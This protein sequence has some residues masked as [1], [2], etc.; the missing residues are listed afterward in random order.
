MPKGVRIKQQGLSSLINWE[1]HTYEVTPDDRATMLAGLGFDASVWEIW[2]CLAIGAGLYQIDEEKRSNP[3][4]LYQWLADQKI[5]ISFLPTPLAEVVLDLPVPDDISLRYLFTGGDALHARQ[6]QELPFT[7]VNH[8]GPSENTVIATAGA[9]PQ[10]L[11]PTVVPHIGRP[12]DNTRCYILDMNLQAVPLGVI[13]E[14]CL[15]GPAVADGYQ[16]QE[17]L[18]TDRFVKNPYADGDWS[19]LYKTGDRAYFNTD[20]TIEFLGRLDD[21]VKIRGFR[22]ELG[23]IES[24]LTRH[25]SIA[26]AAA[27]VWTVNRDDKRVVAYVVP[28]DGNEELDLVSLRKYLRSSLPA[29]MIPTHFL[30]LEALPE[31]SNGKLDR[32]ALPLPSDERMGPVEEPPQ[33]KTEKALAEIWQEILRTSFVSRNSNYFDIGGNSISAMKVVLQV[34]VKLGVSLPLRAVVLDSL[35]QI[36]SF[37]DQNGA[38]TSAGRSGGLKQ[39]LSTMIGSRSRSKSTG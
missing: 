23:D 38:A 3:I 31:T 16:N 39:L 36:A 7:I 34:S 2:P 18:S 30:S 22:I 17:T 11:P 1:Q 13:G 26:Q 27:S 25:A 9:V 19:T 32:A 28:A 6:W 21:Q 37:C 10:D 20:G 15:A 29:Y 4:D 12:I 35:S 33:T 8:Y 24:T 14:L 5:T